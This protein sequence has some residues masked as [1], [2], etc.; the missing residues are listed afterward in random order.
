MSVI[1]KAES[2]SQ[3][4]NAELHQAAAAGF[5]QPNCAVIMPF[6]PATLGISNTFQALYMVGHTMVT[7]HFAHACH[8]NLPQNTMSVNAK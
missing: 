8:N 4:R 2:F 7:Y 3:T 5:Q 1:N 6:E